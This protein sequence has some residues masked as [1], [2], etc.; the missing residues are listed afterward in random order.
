MKHK[1]L[2]LRIYHMKPF[3]G[4]TDYVD[5]DFKLRFRHSNIKAQFQLFDHKTNSIYNRT[6]GIITFLLI[7]ITCLFT[8]SCFY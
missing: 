6:P 5:A 3:I 8:I 7:S 4:L 2:I 1:K